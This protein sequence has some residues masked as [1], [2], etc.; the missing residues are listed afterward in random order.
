MGKRIRVQR[1]GRGTSTF[2]LPP[3]KRVA[4]ARYPLLTK[5][6]K[7]FGEGIVEKLVHD[8]GRG[9]P[10]ALI[11]LNDGRTFYNIACEGM[12]ENQ[13]IQVG[14]NVDKTV[15]NIMPLSEIPE[16][17]MIYNIEKNPEDGGKFA[18]AS[19]SYANIISHTSTG[20]A[21]QFPSGKSNYIHSGSLATIGV[22]AG[23]G[24]TDKIMMRAGER[25]HLMK[26][27]AQKYPMTKGGRMIAALHP[28]G[29]GRHKHAGKPV[30]VSRNAPPGRKVGL[31]AARQTGR[32]RKRRLKVS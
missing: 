1:R 29:G 25:Y 17:T 30:T 16:G 10:L 13:K 3:N 19:G 18:R 11:R 4:P 21:L 9:A 20:T 5:F 31:I 8:P 27:K 14:M 12:H 6:E 24:R 22:A 26:R 32:S 23:A 2:R 15:G 7:R 28:Y